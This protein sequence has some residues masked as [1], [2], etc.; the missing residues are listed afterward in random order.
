[1]VILKSS[2]CP[3]QFELD[4]LVMADQCTLVIEAKT[5]IFMRTIEQMEETL[6]SIE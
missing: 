3:L 2:P 1:M 4:G 6:Q 5:K